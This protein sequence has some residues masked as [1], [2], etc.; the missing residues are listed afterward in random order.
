VNYNEEVKQKVKLN[1][2]LIEQS[3]RLHIEKKE[4]AV[5]AAARLKAQQEEDEKQRIKQKEEEEKKKA[6]A[7]AIQNAQKQ[8]SKNVNENDKYGVNQITFDVYGYYKSKFEQFRKESEAALSETSLKMYK[9]DLQKAINFPLNSLLEDKSSEE[10]KRN[11]A[12]KI[13]TL[14]RLLS[15]QTC[16]INSTLTVN[17]TK[18]PKAIDYCLVFLA[19]KLIEKGEETVGN[20]PETAFQYCQ[21]ITEVLKHVG[22]FE[23][24]LVAQFNEK[25]PYTVPYY[26]TRVNAQSDEQY[27]E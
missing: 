26:K 3:E 4:A 5:V 15:G 12:E 1:E 21:V 11:F 16:T 19:K 25:S 8:T 9:F 17:P 7:A 10:G 14:V 2:G 22:D 23:T 18:H 6:E 13:K 20:R 24:I 27:M